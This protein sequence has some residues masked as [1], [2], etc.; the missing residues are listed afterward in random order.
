MWGILV[1][2]VAF[3]FALYFV[4]RVAEDGWGVR[5]AQGA[6]LALAFFPTAFFFNAA[7]TES[8]FLA[9]SSGAVWAARVKR[10]L[11]LACL[12]AG[13]AAATRNVGVLLLIPLSYEWFE[14]C[15]EYGWRCVYLALAPSGLVAYMAFLWAR[16]GDPL[17]FQKVQNTDWRRE[18]TNPLAVLGDVSGRAFGEVSGVFDPDVR[19]PIV[20]GRDL[21]NLLA[22][23]YNLQNLLFLGFVAA[24]LVLGLRRLPPDL[25]LYTLLLTVPPALFGPPR[26]PLMGFKRYVLVAF[27][28]FVVLGALL[29]NRA[30]LVAWLVPSALAS[31]LY[32]ALFVGWWWVA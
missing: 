7:Y 27:P 21:L 16:F 28:L 29:K 18:F 12:L 15:Q 31:L 1:S 13:L 6:T 17:I 5:A 19:V 24:L 2:L 8:L 25:F 26:D 4:Y 14:N 22:A 20:P 9:F 10:N 3:F 32:C 30:A 11:L 23:S